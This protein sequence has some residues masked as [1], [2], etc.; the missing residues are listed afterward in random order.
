MGLGFGS[1]GIPIVSEYLNYNNTKKTNEANRD[2]NNAQ[3]LFQQNMSNTA[4]QREVTDL[5][6]AGLN[7]ILSAGGQG[8]STPPGSQAEMKAPQ[9]NSPMIF[10]AI[11]AKQT[12]KKLDQDQQRINIEKA[13]S[14]AAIAKNLS[15]AE[16]DRANT[17][18][19]KGGVLTK[20]L[21]TDVYDKT[22]KPIPNPLR[23]WQ[24]G[25]GRKKSKQPL[26]SFLGGM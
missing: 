18:A 16:L 25:E 9:I 2:M 26:G 12:E 24:P 1:I 15:A 22:N 17:S 14:A 13:N 23:N 7:P 19:T 21:G 3:M 20:W 8:S 4:H 11:Q 5:Q 6:A 10:Q